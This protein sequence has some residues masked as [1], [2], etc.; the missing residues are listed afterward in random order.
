MANT[1]DIKNRI[2]SVQNIKKITETMEKIATARVKKNTNRLMTSRDFYF[3]LTRMLSHVIPYAQ[4]EAEEIAHPLLTT[5]EEIEKTLILVISS[6]R[7]LCG[8]YNNN[9]LSLSKRLYNTMNEEKKSPDLFVVGKKGISFFRFAGMPVKKSVVDID[10][11]VSYDKMAEIATELAE[12]YIKQEYN[13]IY[14]VYTRYHSAANQKPVVEKLLP[15]EFEE[16]DELDEEYRAVYDF[17]PSVGDVFNTI[18]PMALNRKLFNTVLETN[19]SEQIARK[20]AMKQAS[21]SA[22]D[23]IKD[24]NLAYNRAR[25]NKI[26]KELIEIIGAAKALQS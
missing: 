3:N 17:E 15:F 24:L 20:V 6:N 2:S 21:D 16:Q 7:G 25:Q 10:D 26:T 22:G 18:L 13:E 8:G 4:E 19:L 14:L 5:H 23:M 11:Q 9:V 1:R 12:L